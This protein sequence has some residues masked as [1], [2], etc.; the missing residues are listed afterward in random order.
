MNSEKTH[1]TITTKST[2][3]KSG[4]GKGVSVEDEKAALVKSGQ[5][6]AY[7]QRRAM[8][9]EEEEKDKKHHKMMKPNTSATKHY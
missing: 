4:H 6:P 3:P 9:V 1:P 5:S 7:M 2:T 8:G